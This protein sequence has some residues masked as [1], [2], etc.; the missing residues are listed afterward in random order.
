MTIGRH[1]GRRRHRKLR[2]ALQ[3]TAAVLWAFS[4]ILAW[5]SGETGRVLYLAAMALASTGIAVWAARSSGVS[6]HD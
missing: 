3:G 6:E 4:A 2:L 5:S 1:D